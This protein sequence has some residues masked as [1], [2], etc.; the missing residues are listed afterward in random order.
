M[1]LIRVLMV[2]VCIGALA[3]CAERGTTEDAVPMPFDVEHG[4]YSTASQIRSEMLARG[5]TVSRITLNEGTWSFTSS[6]DPRS[7]SLSESASSSSTQDGE[8]SS[9]YDQGS[10]TNGNTGCDLY[11]DAQRE[12]QAMIDDGHERGSVQLLGGKWTFIW[13]VQPTA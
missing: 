7:P 9:Q 5:A 3:S 4:R 12:R 2:G 10:T 8:C 11:S 6:M 1:T 13:V